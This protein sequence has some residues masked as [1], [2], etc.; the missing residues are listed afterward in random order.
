MKF[1]FETNFFQT[2]HLTD[3]RSGGNLHIS[4]YSCG[5]SSTVTIR[6]GT[7]KGKCVIQN[8]CETED[9]DT[10]PSEVHVSGII[11]VGDDMFIN[12]LSKKKLKINKSSPPPYSN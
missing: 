11:V 5:G 1:S 9:E 6:G 10:G 4:N 7:V 8:I 12:K 3:V 2:M